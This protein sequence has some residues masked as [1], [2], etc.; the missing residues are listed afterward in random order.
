MKQLINNKDLSDKLI[1]KGYEKVKKYN[2]Y[3]FIK[4]FEKTYNF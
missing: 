1:L 3:N 4:D 2:R